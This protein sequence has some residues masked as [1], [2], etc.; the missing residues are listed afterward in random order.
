MREAATATCGFGQQISKARGWE[1]RGWREEGRERGRGGGEKKVVGQGED[2]GKGRRRDGGRGIKGKRR[3]G[4]G[5]E[6][7]RDD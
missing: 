2:K 6:G 7:V 1:Q 5:R 4:E 3:D